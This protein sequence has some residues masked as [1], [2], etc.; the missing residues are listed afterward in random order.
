MKYLLIILL[1]IGCKKDEVK[2]VE[3][4]PAQVGV[5]IMYGVY[6]WFDTMQPKYYLTK[7][8]LYDKGTT[9]KADIELIDDR[10]VMFDGKVTPIVYNVQT[11]YHFCIWVFVN[12]RQKYKQ[13][14]KNHKINLVL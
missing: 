4:K 11:P 9:F 8:K 13:I 5:Y 2:P 10:N 1:L 7:T 12:G 6:M 14:S 3:Q